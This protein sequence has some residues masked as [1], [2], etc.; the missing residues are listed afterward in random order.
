MSTVASVSIVMGSA[1]LRF[2]AILCKLKEVANLDDWLTVLHPSITLVNFQLDA[3]K[4]INVL[5]INK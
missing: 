5:Y 1:K 2:K 4:S 3:Q